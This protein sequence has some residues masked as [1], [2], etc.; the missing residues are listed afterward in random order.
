MHMKN[1]DKEYSSNTKLVLQK[2]GAYNIRNENL[3]AYTSTRKRALHVR[4]SVTV[5]SAIRPS[6]VRRLVAHWWNK[7]ASYM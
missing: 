3:A 5:Q 7:Y 4:M 1:S 2:G 6:L